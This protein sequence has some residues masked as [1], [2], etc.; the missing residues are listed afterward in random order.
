MNKRTLIAIFC[1]ISLTICAVPAMGINANDKIYELTQNLNEY[2]DLDD[3]N[4]TL[5][6]T[7]LLT[8]GPISKVYSKIEI[9]NGSENE[10][11]LINKF[12]KRSIFRP[13]IP[14]VYVNNLTFSVEYLREPA[15]PEFNHSKFSYITLHMNYSNFINH[16]YNDTE[17]YPYINESI[18]ESLI[19]NKPHK[20]IVENFTGV[21]LFKRTRF[22]RFLPKLHFFEP[23]YFVFGGYCKE[24]DIIM[25]TE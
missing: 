25:Q 9:I 5:N 23:A 3:I 19:I 11:A 1:V 17:N 13:I 15:E 7:V 10:V 8:C 21:F 4:E 12:L 6:Q 16:T 14:M 20:I 22:I 18:N 24:L 2:V